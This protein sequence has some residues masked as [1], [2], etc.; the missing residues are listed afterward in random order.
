MTAPATRI[1]IVKL[2]APFDEAYLVRAV[3]KHQAER[4]VSKRLLTTE[5]AS[6]EILLEL[7]SK[8]CPVLD[9]TKETT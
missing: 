9:A 8:N 1:Y 2:I 7:G 3:S 6:Q 4:F 5:V